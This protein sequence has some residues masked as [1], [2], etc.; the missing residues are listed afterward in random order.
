MHSVCV[1]QPRSHQQL[2]LGVNCTP[3]AHGWCEVA[4]PSA[5]CLAVMNRIQCMHRAIHSWNALEN[6]HF[7][8][9]AGTFAVVL[10]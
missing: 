3:I 5:S 9:R 2:T 10:Q 6:I 8:P 7:S 1:W 4:L